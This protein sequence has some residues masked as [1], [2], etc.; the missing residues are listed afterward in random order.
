[1]SKTKSIQM[2]LVSGSEKESQK[3]SL[4]AV[5]DA[6]GYKLLQFPNPKEAAQIVGEHAGLEF[7]VQQA[8]K[9]KHSSW[10]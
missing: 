7:D 8:Q 2:R 5:P 1:M 9:L 4:A 10:R 3:K 6:F